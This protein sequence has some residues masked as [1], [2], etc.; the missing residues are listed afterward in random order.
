MNCRITASSLGFPLGRHKPPDLLHELTGDH[1]FVN[2]PL[3]LHGYR[4]IPVHMH[5]QR[6]ARG[7]H[8]LASEQDTQ[9]DGRDGPPGVDIG[10]SDPLATKVAIAAFL[11]YSEIDFIVL[12][13]ADL[14]VQ[15]RVT[16]VCFTGG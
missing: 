15:L 3:T 12:E 1:G 11:V 2:P 7:V 4:Q 13:C 8:G 9:A 6:E 5:S 14:V 16:G 10:E